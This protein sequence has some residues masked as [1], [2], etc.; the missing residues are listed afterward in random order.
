M[1]NALKRGYIH[2]KTCNGKGKTTAALGHALRAS[3]A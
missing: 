3:G 2:V 1:T